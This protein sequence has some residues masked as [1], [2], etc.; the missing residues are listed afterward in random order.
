MAQKPVVDL[1]RL[2]REVSGRYSDT[3]HS[4]ETST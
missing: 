3:P 1:G 4:V 2:T